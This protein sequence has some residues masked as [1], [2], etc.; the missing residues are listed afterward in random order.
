MRGKIIKDWTRVDPEKLFDPQ[1]KDPNHQ[2][3]LMEALQ[4]FFALP[5]KFTPGK[6][7]ENK[8]FLEKKK[9]IEKNKLQYFAT[10]N[11][12][13]AT[14]KEVIDKYH[15]LAVYDNGFE[16]IFNIRDYTGSRRDGFAIDNVQSG[17]T[18]RKMLTGEKLDVYQMS[19]TRE[20]VFFDY[21]GGA[22]GWH[23]SLFENQE[24]WTLEE[25]AI[26][27]RNEAYRIRAA[28][29]YALIEAVAGTKADIAWQ[30]HPDGIAAGNRGYLAGRDAA[31]LNLAAQTILLANQTKGYGVSPQN[32]SF[33][34]LAPIQ[35]RA[36]IKQAL[37]Y[38]YDNVGGSPSV[39][40]YNFR[41][42]FTTMLTD[43]DHYWVIFPKKRLVAGYRMDLTTFADFDILSYTDTV[44]G[45]MA[46]GGAI[47]DTDQLERCD[48]A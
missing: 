12:F 48:T 2:R 31:T 43:T 40:D 35:L 25:N 39:I 24:Y 45:W 22:L 28:T 27:F 32:I 3:Q 29:F 13:P 41:P 23:R 36:R 7:A 14:A 17:L 6:F 10:L 30:A 34:I 37:N 19:G 42:I 26:E 21:Y 8:K 20:Y 18:F 15:E 33:V 44:A 11:D 4:F 38:T 9:E 47:A 1:K 16:E 46:F 5:D